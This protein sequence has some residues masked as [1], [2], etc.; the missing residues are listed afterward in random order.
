[1]NNQKVIVITGANRG[2]GEQLCRSFLHQGHLVIGI[3]RNIKKLSS[4]DISVDN[5][6]FLSL[7]ADLNIPET[8]DNAVDT[9]IDKYGRIDVLFNNAA[10]YP[11]S[12]FIEETV[13]SF[14]ETININIIGTA[15]FCKKVLPSMIKQKYG[16][17]YNLGSFADLHPI[18]N[19]AGYSAS[20]GALHALTKAI[21]QDISHLNL[22]IQINEWIPGQLNTEMGLP[23]GTPPE[24]SAEWGLQIFNN[25]S[26]QANNTSLFVNDK[27]WVPP[28]SLKQKIKKRLCFWK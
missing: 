28:T 22:D 8:I 10:I 1:M 3:S 5:P 25:S 24:V 13:Q 20:K 9:I 2:L 7:Y 27:E 16:R 12:N 18:A 17:I 15:L 11:R 26:Q 4:L 21:A 19:S 14:I 6:N 23:E